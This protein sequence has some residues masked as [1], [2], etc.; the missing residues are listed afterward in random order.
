MFDKS[1]HVKVIVACESGADLDCLGSMWTRFRASSTPIIQKRF[2]DSVV[3]YVTAIAKQSGIREHQK[4][5]S[6]EEFIILRRETGAVKV[7]QDK[8]LLFRISL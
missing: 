6:V 3:E 2:I 1:I 4:C 7:I 8:A 5:P